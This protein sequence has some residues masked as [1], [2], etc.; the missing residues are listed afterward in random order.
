MPVITK[1]DYSPCYEG[2]APSV[3]YATN[4]HTYGISNLADN[5]ES[6]AADVYQGLFEKCD[7][8]STVYLM[9]TNC[10]VQLPGGYS[11]CTILYP[12]TPVASSLPKLLTSA[13]GCNGNGVNLTIDWINPSEKDPVVG[14]YKQSLA[15]VVAGLTCVE[16]E[17]ASLNNTAGAAANLALAAVAG[18]MVAR[19]IGRA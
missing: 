18:R 12:C 6:I 2:T 9:S 5:S 8:T 15:G 13:V 3:V 14:C 16:G 4:K 19:A 7:N 11:N 1:R 17:E 10:G